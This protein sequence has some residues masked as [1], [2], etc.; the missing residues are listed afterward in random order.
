[1]FVVASKVD[2]GCRAP[3]QR[4]GMSSPH[5]PND[6][7]MNGWLFYKL[8]WFLNRTSQFPFARRLQGLYS[9]TCQ[10]EGALLRPTREAMRNEIGFRLAAAL[11][12]G[13]AG[14]Q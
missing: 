2:F 4:V 6:N 3:L 12:L 9:R 14:S 5:W 13:E 8:A 1:L 7:K 10:V 11:G